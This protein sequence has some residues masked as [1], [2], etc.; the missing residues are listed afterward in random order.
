MVP[1]ATVFPRQQPAVLLYSLN[2]E[3]CHAEAIKNSKFKIKNE[4]ADDFPAS[5]TLNCAIRER[6]GFVAVN[7]A[8]CIFPAGALR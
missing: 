1:V 2:P 5:L 4:T 7:F 3:K 8:F 6:H